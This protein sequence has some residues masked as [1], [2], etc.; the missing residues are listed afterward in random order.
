MNALNA[1]THQ[2]I[3][4]VLQL[5]KDQRSGKGRWQMQATVPEG[6]SYTLNVQSAYTMLAV[7]SNSNQDLDMASDLMNAVG[8]TME[9]CCDPIIL[10]TPTIWV[11]SVSMQNYLPFRSHVAV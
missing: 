5:Q 2:T 4:D 3:Q 10:A 1:E 7:T 11:D 6:R 9:L 8:T